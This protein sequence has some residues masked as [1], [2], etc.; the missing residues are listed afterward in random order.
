[1]SAGVEAFA[2]VAGCARGKAARRLMLVGA[3]LGIAD[4]S[5]GVALP[6]SGHAQPY[7]ALP[8]ASA[9]RAPRVPP[10]RIPEARMVGG[11]IAPDEIVAVARH[12]GFVPRS[13]PLIR[14]GV[15]V[16][17]ATDRY[18]MDVRLTIDAR[19]GRV[20]AATRLAGAA[21][22]GPVYEGVDAAPRIPPRTYALPSRPPEGQAMPSARPTP[23]ATSGATEPPR[24]AVVPPT[25]SRTRREENNTAG[26]KPM[27]PALEVAAPSLE[28]RDASP[29]ADANEISRPQ[30]PQP[31]A[32][33]L[34]GPGDGA[35]KSPAPQQPI[36][37][38]VVTLE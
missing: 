23:G 35:G 11:V 30:G 31:S 8:D 28:T 24:H 25:L 10:G 2:S 26:S 32:D 22:G 17:F 15:Y 18:L 21:Y 1:M 5:N 34:R 9:G 16:V 27:A 37:A 13:Q 6:T 20:L 33:V 3:L 36:M 29:A 19:S 4:L 12:A 7:D 14:G 38:P